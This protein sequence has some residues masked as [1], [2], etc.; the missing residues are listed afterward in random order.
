MPAKLWNS[1]TAA[2]HR[3]MFFGGAL[4]AVAVMLWWFYEL[5]TRFGIAG[6][7]ATW[8]IVPSAAHAYLMIF[9]L[10]PFF[11]F[12]FLM[13]VFPRWMGGGEIPPQRF[14]PAFSFLLLGA[15]GFYAGLLIN[16]TVLAVAVTSTL[17]G[18][19]AALYTLLRVLLDTDNP[20]KRHP[21]SIFIAVSLGWCSLAAYLIWLLSDSVFILRLAI[22]GGL[23]L[24]LLPVFAS[25]AHRMLP[26]F[27]SSALPQYAVR[28][29]EWPWR[30][31]LAGSAMH[32]LLQLSN[33]S[34]WLWLGDLPM[35]FAAL[36]LSYAW[37]LHRSLRIPLLGVLH[38]GFA[39]MGLSM[40][41]FGIQSLISFTSGNAT[42][43]WGLAPQHALT[44]GCFA[45]LLIGLGT[46]VTLGHSGLPMQV[47]KPVMLMF[48]GIQ[49]V[50][51]LRVLADMLPGQNGYWLY[52]AAAAL[53]LV[54]FFPWVLRYLPVYV[55][56]RVD[57]Q[58][59]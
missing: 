6:Q 5:V 43:Y 11:M 25:V 55:R 13:T 57:G 29:P 31:I 18:W 54:C 15:A 49:L 30:T 2:P 8:S 7:P 40:L 52:I 10:F 34:N 26:F 59:G 28:R 19:G 20:D 37:G 46:R 16:T 22:Q 50:A 4:Q 21:T 51:I 23:W 14:V 39:W 58:A 35:A 3:V 9:G 24:F 17:A 36:Y 27:T 32:A 33:A 12:G 45:T 56:P 42:Q 47:D 1:F 38:I 48:L 44:I 53:W 41:L